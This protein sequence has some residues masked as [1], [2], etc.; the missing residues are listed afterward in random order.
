MPLPI[1][2]IH[3]LKELN[4]ISGHLYYLFPSKLNCHKP[5]SNTVF[6]M[7]LLRLD[8]EER[9]IPH[10]FRHIASTL[11][12]NKSFDERYIE[13]TLAHIRHGVADRY[14]KIQYLNDHK[15]MMQC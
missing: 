10:G 13:V 15:H 1:Q 2:I 12:N 7:A 3:L 9:Q 11:L 6:I 4:Q 14:N 8:Y 5:K